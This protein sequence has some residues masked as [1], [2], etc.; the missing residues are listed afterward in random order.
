VQDRGI[1]SRI[2]DYYG[3]FN[4]KE[5]YL[6]REIILDISGLELYIA[7]TLDL[8][9][10]VILRA[11]SKRPL[12][13]FVQPVGVHPEV[14][15]ACPG[16]LLDLMDQRVIDL[17]HVKIL[18]VSTVSR[19]CDARGRLPVSPLEILQLSDPGKG[20]QSLSKR[21]PLVYSAR[22]RSRRSRHERSF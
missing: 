3:F 6:L 19:Y 21:V 1:K 10:V 8:V 11:C 7:L 17:S 22:P 12:G 9:L 18:V 15:V 20:S 2:T 13:F 14:V 5:T 4:D 16:R